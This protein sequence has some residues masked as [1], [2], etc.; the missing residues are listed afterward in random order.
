MEAYENYINRWIN[1]LDKFDIESE[2]FRD[3]SRN[4]STMMNSVAKIREIECRKIIEAN[5]LAH[6]AKIRDCETIL[7][8]RELKLREKE[9]EDRITELRIKRI[10]DEKRFAH[11]KS[12]DIRDRN[13]R[14]KEITCRQ[15]SLF[16]EEFR[17]V[18]EIL[19]TI[20]GTCGSILMIRNILDFE[21]TGVIASKSLSFIP[22]IFSK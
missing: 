7:K 21:Q 6:E 16:C 4:L 5:R 17:I 15:Q 14:E 19:R 18:A 12:I 1:Q 9:L 3:G 11:E 20:I 2:E 13:I 10:L 22:K 8:E